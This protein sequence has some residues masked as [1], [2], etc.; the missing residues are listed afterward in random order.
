MFKIGMSSC[1]FQIN[2]ENFAALKNSGINYVEVSLASDKFQDFN[3]LEAKKL[4]DEYGINLWSYH[5]PFLPFSKIE[6]STADKGIR[7]YSINLF[8]ELIKK[9]AE[10]GIEKYIIHPS[11]EP[12]SDAE[13]PERLKYSMESLNTLAE[14]AAPLGAVVCVED[15]PRTCLSSNINDMKT[16][17]SAN[18]KLRVCFDVNHLL[19]NSHDDFID[20]FGDKIVTT[21]ISDYDFIDERH[22]LPGE[23]KIDWFALIA[24]LKEVNYDGVWLYELGFKSPNTLERIRDLT[25]D[26]F[27]TNATTLFNGK[28]PPS[29]EK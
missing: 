22:W 21:H 18:D 12:I 19:K 5:L 9:G 27:Y 13:R 17:M 10:I 23:G 29:F 2:A 26:D 28:M 8:A 15:L 14:I 4:S 6:I 25:F 11:G 3:Y 16:L 1:D 24:K 7:E 20:A